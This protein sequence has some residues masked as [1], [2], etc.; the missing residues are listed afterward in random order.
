MTTRRWKPLE[1]NPEALKT[2]AVSLGLSPEYSFHDVLS[3]EEWAIE[4]L[5]SPPLSFLFLYPIT[6]SQ[7]S[8]HQSEANKKEDTTDKKGGLVEV[9]QN[10]GNA[11]GTIAILH[12][13]ANLAKSTDPGIVPDGASWLGKFKEAAEGGT[14]DSMASIVDGSEELE[15]MHKES[16]SSEENS[17]A[18]GT[19]DKVNE[20]FVAFLQTSSGVWEMDGRRPE[21]PGIFRGPVPEGG[22]FAGVSMQAVKGYMER[23]PTNY[24]F[25]IIALCKDV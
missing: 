19:D 16:A 11:C 4:M 7:E 17:T 13:V 20:H 6:P 15:R 2:Y 24:K 14:A 1:S 8:Y 23:D 5:P 25:N 3:T 12:A 9:R 21:G 10:I 18:T 22:S